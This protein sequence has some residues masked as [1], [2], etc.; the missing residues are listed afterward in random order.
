MP[1]TDPL[2]TNSGHSQS[3]YY[4]LNK[5]GSFKGDSISAVE[6]PPRGTSEEEFAPR[7]LGKHVV[8]VAVAVVLFMAGFLRMREEGDLFWYRS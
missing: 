2:L 6:A 5:E 1:E 8:S 3:N 4:F 7:Y